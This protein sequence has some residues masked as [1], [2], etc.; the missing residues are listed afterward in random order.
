MFP[1]LAGCRFNY[2]WFSLPGGPRSPRQRPSAETLAQCS[3]GSWLQQQVI[4]RGIPHPGPWHVRCN[5]NRHQASLGTFSTLTC[6]SAVGKAQGK[7]KNL[8]LNLQLPL[9]T[10]AAKFIRSQCPFELWCGIFH[11]QSDFSGEKE[12]F[13][14]G[15]VHV[16]VEWMR[17]PWPFWLRTGFDQWWAGGFHHG[18]WCLCLMTMAE[19]LTSTHVDCHAYANSTW[20]VWICKHSSS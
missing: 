1:A 11:A 20:K 10:H 5:P 6:V 8:R 18:P 9:I 2:C 4:Y 7:K 17:M 3:W 15:F 19:V 16:L 12:T 14:L 13:P